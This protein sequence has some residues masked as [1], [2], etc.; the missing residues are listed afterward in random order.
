MAEFDKGK[1]G[2]PTKLETSYKTVTPR[3]RAGIRGSRR[4]TMSRT[5][6]SSGGT[7]VTKRRP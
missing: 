2:K 4:T 3:E 7:T 6:R 1:R 5:G